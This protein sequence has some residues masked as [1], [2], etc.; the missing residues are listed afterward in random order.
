[1]YN[2]IKNV[3]AQGDY[4][5][6]NMLDKIDLLWVKNKLTNEEYEELVT[7][8]REGAQ[9]KHSID[10]FEKL[11]ELDKRV[12]ALEKENGSEDT[13]SVEY[14]E[15]EAGKWYYTGDKVSFEGTNYTCIAPDGVVCVWSPSAYPTYW[16]KA[17]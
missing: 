7:L 10:A 12:S 6:K 5:L 2:A 15:Y 11:A 1:M 17:E 8:A 14:P 4:N 3:L 16:E 9:T 13:P